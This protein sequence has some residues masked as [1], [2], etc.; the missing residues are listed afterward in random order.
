MLTVS[1]ALSRWCLG[2]LV[3]CR[4]WDWQPT[5][6]LGRFLTR[7]RGFRIRRKVEEGGG[8]ICA[9]DFGGLR[10]A[11]HF[12]VQEIAPS[13]IW[14]LWSDWL[15]SNR[16]RWSSAPKSFKVLVNRQV[17][18]YDGFWGG[19]FIVA[20]G[21]NGEISHV[22]VC[23][24]GDLVGIRGDWGVKGGGEGSREADWERAVILARI[25]LFSGPDMRCLLIILL[26]ML[27]LLLQGLGLLHQHGGWRWWR[28]RW[29][30]KRP[31]DVLDWFWKV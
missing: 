27:D 7:L 21:L 23:E 12:G 28:R 11:S 29:V 1:Q 17:G 19:R 18:V 5:G 9:V 16:A 15:N 26:Q 4:R 24:M 2:W 8:W 3:T 14:T 22:L 25:C 31:L 30:R 6:S 20:W 10:L 13:A